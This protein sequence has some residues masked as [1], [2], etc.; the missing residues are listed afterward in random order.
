MIL[1]NTKN[2]SRVT[3]L[4]EFIK[5]AMAI[6]ITEE[7]ISEI[8]KGLL[9]FL[10]TNYLKISTIILWKKKYYQNN[11]NYN[12]TINKNKMI[13]VKVKKIM[14]MEIYITMNK[15][16]RNIMKKENKIKME[17]YMMANIKTIKKTIIR[18]R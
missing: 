7:S 5:D 10:E 15:K 18:I 6:N 14:K 13:K 17:I 3:Q 9:I 2:F 8:Q 1:H 16:K 4:L 12:K 11:N